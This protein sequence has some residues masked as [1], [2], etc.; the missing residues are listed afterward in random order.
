MGNLVSGWTQTKMPTESTPPHSAHVG[1][2]DPLMTQREQQ[3]PK[4]TH[5]F[6]KVYMSCRRGPGQ[7]ICGPQSPSPRLELHWKC[8][9]NLTT[10]LQAQ[11]GARLLQRRNSALPQSPATLSFACLPTSRLLVKNVRH[12]HSRAH[13]DDAAE[14]TCREPRPCESFWSKIMTRWRDGL[15]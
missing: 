4:A 14:H 15:R 2:V 8:R 1:P 12:A 13:S 5:C 9:A 10:T 6:T 7:I 3:M 11:M